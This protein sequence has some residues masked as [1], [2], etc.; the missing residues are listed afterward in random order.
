MSQNQ[1]K[2][3]GALVG[4]RV[5]EKS[6]DLITNLKPVFSKLCQHEQWKNLE[7]DENHFNEMWDEMNFMVN[8]PLMK[9]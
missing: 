7:W 1:K 6:K 9:I 5:V 2:Y 4:K 8:I 3:T